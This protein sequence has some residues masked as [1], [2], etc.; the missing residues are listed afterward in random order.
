MI[1]ITGDT[2]GTID[3]NSLYIYFAQRYVSRKDYLIVL[4][5]AGIVWDSNYKDTIVL[6]ERLGLTI[7]F[8]DGNHENFD[9]LNSFEVINK[10][11]AKVHKISEYIFHVLRGEILEI[12]GLSFLCVGGAESI[13]KAYR[14]PG[15]SWWKQE[16]ITDDD[17]KNAMSNIKTHNMKVDYVLTH[18]VP[19]YICV[20]KFGFTGDESTRQLNRLCSYIETKHWYFGHYHFDETIDDTFR[21]FYNDVLEIDK[22]NSGSKKVPYKLLT[23]SS[24]F[25]EYKNCPFLINWNTGRKTKL[26]EEDLPEWYYHNFSYRDW[27]YCIKGVKDVAYKGSPFDNHINKDSSI[28]LSYSEKIEKNENYEPVEGYSSNYDHTWRCDVVDFTYALEKYSPELDLTNLKAHI[29][30][31][32][33]Q[34]NRNEDNWQNKIYPR[35]FPEIETINI[36]GIKYSVINEYDVLCNFY[37]LENAKNFCEF[38]LK[39][40][41]KINKYEFIENKRKYIYAYL[42]SNR[43]IKRMVIKKV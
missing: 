2:H 25:D 29:N 27:Y 20:K 5:D 8:I 31:T 23:K 7:F 3:F 9:L 22:R 40:N 39:N 38:Y 42:D 13:D 21:C 16:R 35:P 24:W 15:I 34:Y 36:K 10:N 26:I 17:I 14:K 33:D 32:Y 28:F 11:N 19:D 37:E 30:L 18:C 41:L 4:G 6:Y 12:N 1:Y 43:G